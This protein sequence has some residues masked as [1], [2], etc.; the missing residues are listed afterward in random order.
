M[1]QWM[2]SPN[3]VNGGLYL[4]RLTSQLV[5]LVTLYNINVK[6]N[7]YKDILNCFWNLSQYLDEDQVPHDLQSGDLC[8]VKKTQFKGLSPTEMEETISGTLN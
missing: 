4:L 3:S 7:Y 5:P 6:I 1:F 2:L 8:I